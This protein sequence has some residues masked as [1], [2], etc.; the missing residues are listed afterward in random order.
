VN[1]GTPL[2]ALEA[3]KSELLEP[4]ET[5][6]CVRLGERVVECIIHR[7]EVG[8][9]VVAGCGPVELLRVVYTDSIIE[10]Q[11]AADEWRDSLV[12]S[13]FVDVR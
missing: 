4:L 10:A 5:R 12:V 9:A 8:F 7:T 6:W 1:P 2:N 13:G 11:S 3:S